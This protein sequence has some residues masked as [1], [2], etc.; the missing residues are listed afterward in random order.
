M[1]LSLPQRTSTSHFPWCLVSENGKWYRIS[2]LI[3]VFFNHIFASLWTILPPF[4]CDP[5]VF[6]FYPAKL[7]VSRYLFPSLS[8]FPFPKRAKNSHLLS[9]LVPCP[10]DANL[11]LLSHL[12]T[13]F[14]QRS[15]VFF[16]VYS[17]ISFLPGLQLP[18]YWRKGNLRGCK[19][20]APLTGCQVV[21][22]TQTPWGRGGRSLWL[23]TST[24][25]CHQKQGPKVGRPAGVCTICLRVKW[26]LRESMHRPIFRV[27]CTLEFPVQGERRIFI[28]MQCGK[29]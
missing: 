17:Q 24:S 15:S 29:S 9:I 3:V 16:S 19:L 1:F 2:M 20:F 28:S 6:P 22:L 10:D 4:C 13:P 25:R 14:I 5:E 23:A 11:L 18:Q 21:G 7:Q 12:L 27:E 8:K 26:I